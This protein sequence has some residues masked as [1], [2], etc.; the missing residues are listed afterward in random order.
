MR[1]SINKPISY[2]D[3]LQK[4]V[5]MTRMRFDLSPRV[6]T[7]V[8]PSRGSAAA[9]SRGARLLETRSANKVL[10]CDKTDKRALQESRHQ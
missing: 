10:K 3:P 9:Q 1:V 5:G 7:C 4:C 6:S 8:I 2:R